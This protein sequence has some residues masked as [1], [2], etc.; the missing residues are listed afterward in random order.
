M[1]NK[2]LFVYGIAKK[3]S[4]KDIE[5]AIEKVLLESTNGLSW[6]KK[7]D[8]VLLKPTLNSNDPYP[9]TTDP[10]TLK[11]VA[12]LLHKKGAKVILADQSG[13]EHVIQDKT[14][15][16]KGSSQ[17]CFEDS[18][19]NK[20]GLYFNALEKRGWNSFYKFNKT[21][22]WTKGFYISDIV[23]NVDHIINLP[24]VSTHA[25]AGV[26]LGFKNFVG[27]LREDS[28]LEFHNSGPFKQ[29]INA[30]AKSKSKTLKTN[31]V[32]ENNFFEKITEIS[33]ATKDKL[34]LTLFTATKLQTT[35]GP[36]KKL[37]GLFTSYIV[38]PEIGLVFASSNQVATE[39]LAIAFLILNYKTIPENKKVLQ[40]LLITANGK[41]KELGKE[42]VWDNLFIKSAL[43]LKL[44]NKNFDVNYN[45]VPIKLQNELMNILN[46]K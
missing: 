35:F 37:M 9:A 30:F 45:N 11:V 10:L 33:L 43:K 7:G 22:A 15:I 42:N 46:N 40:K 27:L 19:M 13:I 1:I 28:R 38:E 41:I 16:L 20:S 18:G 6:L 29:A 2:D 5:N 31:Y 23:K 3:A 36:D 25:Q 32:N 21:K 8:T 26:T 17:K 12:E 14:G 4:E 34:R 44:G 39:A 24:R